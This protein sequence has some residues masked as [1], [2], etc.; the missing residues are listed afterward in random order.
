MR[1]YLTSTICR[2]KIRYGLLGCLALTLIQAACVNYQYIPPT[3]DAGRQCVA[4]CDAPQQACIADHRQRAE[5]RVRSCQMERSFRLD[6]CLASAGSDKD[7]QNCAQAADRSCET[8][9]DTSGCSAE[10]R[11]CYTTCGG[12][13]AEEHH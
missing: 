8:A 10:F 1:N 2:L 13:V 9:T 4:A 12:Q 7:R 3:T 11:R 5:N 6:Q